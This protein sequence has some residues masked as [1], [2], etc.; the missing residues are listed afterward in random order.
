MMR[1]DPDDRAVLGAVLVALAVAL[2]HGVIRSGL[3]PGDA[4][5]VTAIVLPAGFAL[6]VLRMESRRAQ[7]LA[8]DLAQAR[9]ILGGMLER[10]ADHVLQV[11]ATGRITADLGA[12]YDS[13]AAL[14][15][16]LVG[17]RLAD[18]CDSQ[19]LLVERLDGEA[20]GRRFAVRL[21]QHGDG[22]LAFLRDVTA[23]KQLEQRL[24]Q[25][26][27]VDSL[28]GL[29]NRQAFLHSLDECCARTPDPATPGDTTN[30]C[31]ALFDIDHL[32]AINDRHGE[33]AGDAVLRAFVADADALVRAGDS[34]S[35]IGG[36]SFAVIL[37]G[38]D[39]VQ[40]EK[41]AQRLIAQFGG[42]ARAIGDS[43]VR[44]TASA[45]VAVWQDR[46]AQTM[47]QAERALVTAKARGHNRV[48][49]AGAVRRPAGTRW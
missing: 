12:H 31:I 23:Q 18:Q 7:A 20:I 36:G 25:V 11:G 6:F 13:A 24:G 32:K 47:R 15:L 17:S 35:R 16:P 40:A 8:A 29:P 27:Q 9:L 34:L 26:A 45:G 2:G 44:V 4:G 41:V 42:T 19:G 33:A 1:A 10:G 49:V 30:G 5:L 3:I 14:D 21:V 22:A 37:P 48:E 38:A 28:T 43:I 46:A 39:S